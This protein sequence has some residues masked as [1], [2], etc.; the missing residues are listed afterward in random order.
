[1][2]H[3]KIFSSEN[4]G[5]NECRADANLLCLCLRCDQI[6]C[7]ILLSN[8][9]QYVH[10]VSLEWTVFYSVCVISSRIGNTKSAC[11]TDG[12][13]MLVLFLEHSLDPSLKST[14]PEPHM[15]WYKALLV[16]ITNVIIES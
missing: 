8:T 16:L 12:T 9:L 7:G 5:F 1:M 14:C 2:S 13:S 6:V 15:S 3:V 4:A 11:D 10:E